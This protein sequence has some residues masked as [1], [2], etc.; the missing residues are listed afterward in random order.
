MRRLILSKLT[1]GTTA[2]PS[3]GLVVDVFAKI[4]LR[5]VARQN[6]LR[7]NPG[8]GRISRDHLWI[9]E[10]E[11]KAMAPPQWK[12]GL[13]YP[14]PLSLAIRIGRFFHKAPCSSGPVFLNLEVN[15]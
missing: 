9:T 1:S 3:D 11:V 10:S 6:S 15:S 14:M 7:I 2:P 5:G 8:N 13:T 12:V 4:L